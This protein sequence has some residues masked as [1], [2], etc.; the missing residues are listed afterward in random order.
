MREYMYMHG[1]L[2]AC[3]SF[4]YVYVYIL[5]LQGDGFITK[6]YLYYSLSDEISDSKSRDAYID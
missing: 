6:A 1:P 4:F 2:C 5:V 3:L